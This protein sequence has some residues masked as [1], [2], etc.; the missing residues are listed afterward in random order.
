MSAAKTQ[1]KVD[2]LPA[3]LQA[4]FAALG[5]GRHFLDFLN[6]F[7]GHEAL[8]IP[9][10]VSGFRD[11]K[12][13]ARFAASA[14]KEPLLRLPMEEGAGPTLAMAP[15]KKMQGGQTLPASREV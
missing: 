5:R 8:L 1:P 15:P 3:D 11:C 13:S 4:V 2:P 6:V 10:G 9:R 7:A 12:L 14:N